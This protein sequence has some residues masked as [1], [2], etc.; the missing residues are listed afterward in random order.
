[1]QPTAPECGGASAHMALHSKG[2][3]LKAVVQAVLL[4]TKQQTHVTFAKD[5][6][7]FCR[8]G[9]PMTT[10]VT[11]S[12]RRGGAGPSNLASAIFG[13]SKAEGWDVAGA[14]HCSVQSLPACMAS[15]WWR[16]RWEWIWEC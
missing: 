14:E 6:S 9:G 13:L 7:V 11:F 8:I 5:D 10:R 4:S 2:R 3:K 12:G 1:M 15:C 16:C